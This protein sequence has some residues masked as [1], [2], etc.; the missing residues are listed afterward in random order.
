MILGTMSDGV[1]TISPTGS[2]EIDVPDAVQQDYDERVV[3]LWIEGDDTLL[4]LSSFRRTSAGPLP[5]RA[6]LS[7]RL[8]KEGLHNVAIREEQLVDC[9]DSA[10]A[11]GTDKEGTHWIYT[12]AVWPDLTLL[13][14]ASHPKRLPDEGSWAMRALHTLRRPNANG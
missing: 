10:S 6:R 3:S 7:A 8:A 5:A 9:G 4:Q 13:A 1:K 14:T 2:Y 12:Y 11:S